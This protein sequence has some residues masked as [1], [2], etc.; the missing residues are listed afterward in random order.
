MDNQNQPITES[1]SLET[2]IDAPDK[3]GVV[4]APQN[5][6]DKGVVYTNKSL[7]DSKKDDN[8]GAKQFLDRLN[9]YSIALIGILFVLG[10]VSYYAIVQ[11]R[12]SAKATLLNT[13]KLTQDTLNKLG[14]T[15]TT[16]GDPKQTL[17]IES[18]AI[19]TGGVIIR[20]NTDIAGT[21]KIGGPLSLPGLSVGGTANLEQAAVKSLTDSGDASIQGK[22]TIQNGLSVSGTLSAT[23]ISADS[24]QLNKDLTLSH[25]ITGSGG[26][27]GHSNGNA[28][29]GGGTSSNSGTDISGTVA[30]NTGNSAPAGCFITI[31]F[32]T[33]YASTP[34]VVISPSSSAAASISY[35]VN[36]SNNNFSICT[37]SDPPD[38]TA[39]II[40]DYVVVS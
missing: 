19:F 39:G 2:P 6:S 15:D 12:K 32:V 37:A 38:N 35:Y 17:S 10:G 5:A 28:L 7:D 9:L 11:N 29:G 18:N 25:H 30:I 4:D 20:G 22:V 36:R 24:L 31:N 34:H 33:N 21:L 16:V 8:R 40:F 14:G 26:T 3:T 23:L 1:D 27:P 13:Q